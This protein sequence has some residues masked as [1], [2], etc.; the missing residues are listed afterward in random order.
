MDRL[1]AVATGTPRL[2]LVVSF[3]VGLASFPVAV[4][5]GLLVDDSGAATLLFWGVWA[6]ASFAFVGAAVV[7]S[8]RAG[9]SVFR[10]MLDGA[11]AAVW[12]VFNSLP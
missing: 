3:L 1:A 7:T 4:V 11:R 5:F 10:V 9:A 12:L 6:A 2:V 8:R